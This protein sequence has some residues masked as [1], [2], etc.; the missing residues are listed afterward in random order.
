[1][2]NSVSI[3][4]R[5]G[6]SNFKKFE[7]NSAVCNLSIAVDDSYYNK[8]NSLVERVQWIDAVGRNRIAELLNKHFTKGDQV[9]VTGKLQKRNYT[10]ENGSTIYVTEV[11]IEQITFE[12]CRSSQN[13]S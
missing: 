11:V 5:I 1:M 7:D 8:D 6:Q 12:A 3:I 13:K 10:A 4:G 9:A 2:K